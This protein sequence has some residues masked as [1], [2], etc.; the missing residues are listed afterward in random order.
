MRH[1]FSKLHSNLLFIPNTHVINHRIDETLFQFRK[2]RHLDIAPSFSI[3]H[4]ISPTPILIDP[5]HRFHIFYPKMV[6]KKNR[7][8]RRWRMA[9]SRTS[10]GHTP[11]TSSGTPFKW[12]PVPWIQRSTDPPIHRGWGNPN[13]SWENKTQLPVDVSLKSIRWSISR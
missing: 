4:D 12:P 6:P 5:L 7:P 10:F 1:H 2:F 9:P 8:L 13:I 11:T 3:Y